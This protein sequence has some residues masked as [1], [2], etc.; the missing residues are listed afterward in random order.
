MSFVAIIFINRVLG[1]WF[2]IEINRFRF[3]GFMWLLSQDTTL[4]KSILT[5][6]SVHTLVS[7]IL[8][9]SFLY[10]ENI[11]ELIFFPCLIFLSGSAPIYAWI[12]GI[13]CKMPFRALFLLV[14]VQKYIPY[15]IVISMCD[16]SRVS[17]WFYLTVFFAGSTV[18]IYR[19]R[20][21]KRL[22]RVYIFSDAW[23]WSALITNDK[24]YFYAYYI[25]STICL[26]YLLYK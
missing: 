1:L 17:V 26:F 18:F 16:I 8:F 3:I 23:L 7:F 10:D 14:G 15:L 2:I 25:I 24:F 19:H 6:Y 4:R 11:Y 13:G 12:I 21:K 5:Y 22:I 9:L 20:F